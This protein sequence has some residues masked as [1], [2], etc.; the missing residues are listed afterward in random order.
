MIHHDQIGFIPGMQGWCTIRKSINVVH[1]INQLKEREN[2]M[3]ILL[4]TQNT[5]EKIQHLF[6]LKIGEIS[7]T[8]CTLKHNKSNTQQAN[9]QYKIKWREI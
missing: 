9:S 7:S 5:F 2:H 6:M 1:Y 3:N 4:D 8:R